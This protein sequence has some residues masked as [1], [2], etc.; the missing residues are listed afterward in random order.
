MKRNH[1]FIAVL[2]STLLFACKK[3]DNTPDP[4]PNPATSS[5]LL[6]F[7]HVWGPNR[8]AWTLG[9]T[10]A[11]PATGD[12]LT[13]NTLN[14]YISNV[15]L[16]RADGSEYVQPE[17]Y[18]LIKLQNGGALADL[19]LTNIPVGDY[20]AI[21][22][23]IGVD[24]TRNVSGVQEGALSPSNGMFW[25]WTTGYIFVKAEGNSPQ[26]P[27]GNFVYHL[28]GFRGE[29]NAIRT[30]M[31]SFNGGTLRVR[32]NAEPSIH[33]YVNVARF[34]HGGIRV[35]DLHTIHMPGANASNMASNFR[36]AFVFDHLHN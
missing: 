30:N 3:D 36:D 23:T 22:Y 10:K 2:C 29:N 11:H 6:K 33:L 31:H 13:F 8:L 27:N 21:T 24:S 28:G 9:E 7:D 32:Q 1:F 16:R 14:Y 5:M 19:Q 17:S 34:W 4:D 25:S 15:K 12:T 35:S 18:H 26:S 20:T